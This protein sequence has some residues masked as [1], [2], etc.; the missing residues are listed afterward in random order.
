MSQIN[1]FLLDEEVN[2]LIEELLDKKN[3]YILDPTTDK[4]VN[5]DETLLNTQVA[6]KR[7][8]TLVDKT[9]YDRLQHEIVKWTHY[10][11]PIIEFSLPYLLPDNNLLSGR[12]YTKTGYCST[13]E[14]N[15]RHKSSYSK[16]TRLI[17]SRCRRVDNI[18]WAS[19]Q[20]KNWSIE[21]Q[22]HLVFGAIGAF[23]RPISKNE[24]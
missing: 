14:D 12:F 3:F 13:T 11:A 10:E 23:S 18:W 22:N 4:P 20:V 21:T 6:S 7:V 1:F 15:K 19:D 16:L 9:L 8:L 5:S 24:M 2:S 17:K